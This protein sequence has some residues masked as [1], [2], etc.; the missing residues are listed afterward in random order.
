MEKVGWSYKFINF[1]LLLI[2][3]FN[4]FSPSFTKFVEAHWMICL[5]SLLTH[6]WTFLVLL[7]PILELRTLLWLTYMLVFIVP[8]CCQPD[9]VLKRGTQGCHCV[10]PIK[11]DLLLLN[12]SQTSNGD[13]YLNQFAIQLGLQD[14]QIELTSFKVLSL[15]RLNIS[16]DIVPHKGIS[17]SAS[18]AST[19]NSS[20]VMHKVHVDPAL[21]GDYKLLNLT[22]FQPPP[23][24]PGNSDEASNALRIF[25]P[26]YACLQCFLCFGKLVLMTMVSTFVCVCIPW[27]FLFNLRD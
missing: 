24:S 9:M 15:S 19:I 6:I 11:L 20:L 8:D 17:F 18:E 25:S 10:Y 14:S 22:W 21:V 7:L 2:Y 27:C 16:M 26:I 5:T 12:V 4:L 23:P 1:I 3:V 13:L